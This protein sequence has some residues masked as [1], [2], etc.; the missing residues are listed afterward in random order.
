MHILKTQIYTG[1]PN[2]SISFIPNGTSFDSFTITNTVTDSVMTFTSTPVLSFSDYIGTITADFPTV[3]GVSYDLNVLQGADVIYRG[4][5]FCT[6]QSYPYSMTSGTISEVQTITGENN[7]I[8][9]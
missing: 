1:D 6:D 4:T 8:T 9:F 3:E 7:F 5:V 2:Q